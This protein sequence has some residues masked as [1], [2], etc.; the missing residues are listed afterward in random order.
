VRWT[1]VLGAAIALF[2]ACGEAKQAA[3][4]LQG[5][6]E[7]NASIDREQVAFGDEFTLT[8]EV[9]SDP[10]F[11]IEVPRTTEFDGF[12][13]LDSGSTHSEADGVAIE[14]RWMRLRA[15]KTGRNTL[16]AFEVKYRPAPA[17]GRPGGDAPAARSGD[18]PW[19]TTST[20]SIE[21]DVQS[22]L[23]AGDEPPQIRD[24][25]PLQEIDRPQPWLWIA[26]A[27]AAVLAIAAAV[28]YWL[29]RRRG[30]EVAAPPAPPIPAH[31]VAL[32]ALD[33][34]AAEE[35][36]GTP[37]C[38]A[39]TSRCPRSCARTSRAASGS[40]PPIS[41]P[42]RSFPRSVSSLCPQSVRSSCGR[43]CT[44]PMP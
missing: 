43:S 19:K 15:E 31:V 44:T 1:A 25:K 23:P 4:S 21:L 17:G 30:S 39:T 35:P 27:I 33:R 40:T 37:R 16:P 32:A 3:G 7:A 38:A 14:R 10:T 34:L 22:H 11:E 29:R 42:R 6:A 28:A 9:R 18:A 41:R 2:L 12:R 36:G 20:A 24:I 13:F 8:V 5:R 26:V